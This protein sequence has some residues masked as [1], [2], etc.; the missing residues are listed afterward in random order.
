VRS[1]LSGWMA[2]AGGPPTTAI[3]LAQRPL[4]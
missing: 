2:F 1:P 4:G 3:V